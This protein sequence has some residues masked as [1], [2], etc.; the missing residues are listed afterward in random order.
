MKN[1]VSFAK[2]IMAANS[3]HYFGSYI[4][5]VLGNVRGDKPKHSITGDANDF[6]N[7]YTVSLA[8]ALAVKAAE[9][10]RTP[11]ITLGV[12]EIAFASQYVL[13]STLS[14]L[15]KEAGEKAVEDYTKSLDGGKKKKSAPSRTRASRAGLELSVSKVENIIRSVWGGDMGSG[16]PVYLAGVLEYILSEIL[17]VSSTVTEENKRSTLSVAFIDSAIYNDVDLLQLT[18]TLFSDDYAHSVFYHL[19]ALPEDHLTLPKG[20]KKKTKNNRASPG[21]KT[22]K[23][24]KALRKDDSELLQLPKT[25]LWNAARLI[26]GQVVD[27]AGPSKKKKGRKGKK[28]EPPKIGINI[29][30]AA[31]DTLQEYLERYLMSQIIIPSFNNTLNVVKKGDTLLPRHITHEHTLSLEDL[32]SD[33]SLKSLHQAF[34]NAPFRHMCH[35]AG[36]KIVGREVVVSLKNILVQELCR[37]INLSLIT[38]QVRGQKT[39]TSTDIF[40]ACGGSFISSHVPLKEYVTRFN[41]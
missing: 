19:P 36:V 5:K 14:F 33:E 27:T 41:A 7:K 29:Q 6:L 22:A 39:I 35:R 13:P 25:Q 1:K 12:K 18:K 2:N 30:D 34:Y 40:Q 16:A 4:S 17:E 9:F 37:I 31:V 28:E 20:K 15:A 11:K 3:N 8:S 23:M 38:T 21:V 10:T 24:I 26:I 32:E